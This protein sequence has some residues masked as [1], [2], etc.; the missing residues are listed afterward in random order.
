VR[1][2]IP[3]LRLKD[4]RAA[5]KITVLNLL[6]HTAG[7]DWALLADTGDGDDA[8]AAYVARLDELKTDRRAGSVPPTASPDT[9]WPGGSSRR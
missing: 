8:L 7:L 3:M 2:Y 5:A 1:R 9:T 6:N 4:E